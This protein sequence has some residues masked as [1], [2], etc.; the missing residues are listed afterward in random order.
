MSF[1]TTRN[2]ESVAT[3][4]RGWGAGRGLKGML[5]SAVEIENEICELRA[6]I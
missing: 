4:D 5:P 6:K 3:T 1:S 2:V